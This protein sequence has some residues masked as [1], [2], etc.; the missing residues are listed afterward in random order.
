MFFDLQFS[1]AKFLEL[2][3]DQVQRALPLIDEEFSG[4]VID[5]LDVT[6]VAVDSL[7]PATIAIAVPGGTQNIQGNK[8]RIKIDITAKTTLLQNIINAGHLNGLAS[9]LPFPVWVKADISASA[10][11][12]EIQLAIVPVEAGGLDADQNAS[13]LAAVEPLVRA[14]PLPNVAGKKLQV[15]NAGVTSHN[16]VIA[17]QAELTAPAGSSAGTWQSFFAGNFLPR[18][19]DWSIVLPSA[20]IVDITDQ[21]IT[22]AVKAIPKD[23][24]NVEIVS[25]PATSWAGSGITSTA[26]IN[27]VDACPV[28]D[29]DIEADLNFFVTFSLDNGAIKVTVD[30]SWDLN[31]WDVFV[32]GAATVLVPG[33]VATLAAGAI[34]GP[35][36]AIIA[37]IAT[38]VLFIVGI[39]KI[40]D[41]GHAKLSEGVS[42]IDPGAMNLHTVTKDNSHAVIEGSVKLGQFMLGM[43]PTSVT[44][45]PA[46][47]QIGGTLDVPEHK[48]RSLHLVGQNGLGYDSGY[49]CSSYS[50]QVDQI[51][52]QVGMTEPANYP[53]LAKAQMLTVPAGAYDAKIKL[54]SPV[55]GFSL[56]VHSNLPP[57][58]G[59]DCELI[60]WT[61]SGVRYAKFAHLPKAPDPPSTEQLIKGK[62]DCMKQQLPGPKKWLEAHWLIDPPPYELV[63]DQVRMWD[64]IAGKLHPGVNVEVAVVGARG[65]VRTLAKMPAG[66]NG[67]A[68][69]R[70]LTKRGE[71]IAVSAEHGMENMMLFRGGVT[72]EPVARFVPL[73]KATAATVSGT[74]AQARVHIDTATEA[75]QFGMTGKL[76]GHAPLAAAKSLSLAPDLSEILGLQEIMA[77]PAA[78]AMAARMNVVSET[79]KPIQ[80]PLSLAT[81]QAPTAFAT[82]DTGKGL[83]ERS[84]PERTNSRRARWYAEPWMKTP[85]RPGNLA[86]RV[87]DGAVTVYQYMR[88]RVF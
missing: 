24:P 75:L 25:L 38:I 1:E 70:F 23:E 47:L 45:V 4:L 80:A 3:R 15:F 79:T 63:I 20:L 42:G 5:H 54:F 39:V 56:T 48:E 11:D 58:T 14:L 41:E 66:A 46:G 21:A 16:G 55:T 13:L 33:A 43:T 59:P 71:S 81:I 19:G 35:V 52:A 29:S 83:D 68:A 82:R 40:S 2:L 50:W 36:G 28:F 62:V 84:T 26:T 49:S 51:E 60:I 85:I 44:A 74:G 57:D 86:A 22:D 67:Q 10:K 9:Y 8:V 31:D 34:F 30:V 32:C 6:S 7:V 69:F 78:T 64:V 65:D 17:I 72:L 37:V 27:S 88:K 12:G 61:N 18:P 73:S 53:V 87:E 76:L 77:M